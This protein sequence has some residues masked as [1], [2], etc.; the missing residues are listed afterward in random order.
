MRGC[1]KSTA[2]YLRS[3]VKVLLHL[4]RMMEDS[5]SEGSSPVGIN[6][7]RPRGTEWFNQ[8]FQRHMNSLELELVE[9]RHVTLGPSPELPFSPVRPE[10]ARLGGEETLGTTR[11]VAEVVIKARSPTKRIREALRQDEA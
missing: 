3:R 2:H 4:A 11:Q 1:V 9:V 6:F 8:V 10:K 5:L 7:D